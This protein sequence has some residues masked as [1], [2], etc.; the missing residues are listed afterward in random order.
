MRPSWP[1]RR[2]P[3]VFPSSRDGVS[4]TE[5]I[6]IGPFVLTAT[7]RALRF[8]DEPV[9]LSDTALEVLAAIARGPDGA[10]AAQLWPLM[11]AE[12]I[13]DEER[14]CELVGDINTGLGRFWSTLYVAWYPDDAVPRFAFVDATRPARPIATLPAR[15]LDIIG[16]D[17]AVARIA[18]QLGAHRFVTILG[19]GGLG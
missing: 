7:P 2:S 12:T 17:D 13:L 18:A 4:L 9:E 11:S 16:R 6:S 15:R 5:S 19:A 8:G 14:L 3:A 1:R 10:S